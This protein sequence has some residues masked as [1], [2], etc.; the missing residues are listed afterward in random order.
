MMQAAALDSKR[1][2]RPDTRPLEI[3]DAAIALFVAQGYRRTTLE[4][5]AEAAGVT[6]GAIYHY[7]KGK[8]DL[9]L[10][11]IDRRLRESVVPRED[12]E[13]NGGPASTRLRILLRHVWTI[14]MHPEAAQFL[15]FLEGE[16]LCEHPELLRRWFE[17]SGQPLF[18]TLEDILEAGVEAGEFRRDLDIPVLSEYLLLN[19]IRIAVLYRNAGRLSIERFLP[20]RVLE[21]ILDVLFRGVRVNPGP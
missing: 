16:L 10:R 11:A 17:S 20:E 21:A 2:R 8:E 14:W 3:M 15:R 19:T 12:V 1:E 7:F 6:R 5:V 9:L 18:K 13:A 4:D